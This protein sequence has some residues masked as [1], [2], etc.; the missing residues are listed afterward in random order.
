MSEERKQ[1]MS[2]QFK[3]ATDSLKEKSSNVRSIVDK[4]DERKKTEEAKTIN[5]VLSRISHL[6]R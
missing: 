6:L 3:S 4:L 5:N 1:Q 2:F